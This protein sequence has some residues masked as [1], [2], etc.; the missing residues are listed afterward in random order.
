[1]IDEG[2]ASAE[3]QN[4]LS[5]DQTTADAN[6]SFV[7]GDGET[8]SSK[9]EHTDQE[10]FTRLGN[11]GKGRLVD[12]EEESTFPIMQL[13]TEI[14]LEIYRACL[15][16]PKKILLSKVEKPP[17]IQSAGVQTREEET[18]LAD[19]AQPSGS[20][21]ATGRLLRRHLRTRSS[22]Q[23]R[24]SS[25]TISNR[26]SSGSSTSPASSVSTLSATNSVPMLTPTTSLTSGASD[27]QSTKHSATT[28]PICDDR[29]IVNILRISRE[30][31]KEARDVLYSENI[32]EIDLDNAIPS[33]AALHQRS[34]RHI[35]HIELSIPTYTDILERFSEVVR[36]SLRYC[37][38]L[39]TLVIR[40]PF[41][42][43]GTDG[44]GS[45]GNA[46]VYAN[47]FDILR[48]LPQQCQVVLEG[49][50]NPEIEAVVGKHLTLAK[51]QD[52][53]RGALS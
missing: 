17:Q 47:G 4:G 11:K 41:T 13:P 15:T 12:A 31:Y 49:C 52:K 3:G 40:T 45:V 6:W 24:S 43:P 10:P 18:D 36:L 20:S 32:F 48:W 33:L 27:L 21:S 28:A 29:L 1:M 39:K 22:L 44:A 50:H 19:I 46:T 37:T 25:L 8:S 42:L 16:R 53:V 9:V 5:G 2:L 35:K 23:S 51:T 30:I 34:R 38:G 7:N 14:R 26:S